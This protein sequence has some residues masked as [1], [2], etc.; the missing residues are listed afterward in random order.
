MYRG[1]GAS[2]VRFAPVVPWAKT[3]PD[4][5]NQGN[6]NNRSIGNVYR[7]FGNQTL[8]AVKRIIVSGA[9]KS[10]LT[11]VWL[12]TNDSIPI[13]KVDIV[14]VPSEKQTCDANIRYI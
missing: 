10:G 13:R 12:T 14:H 2:T 9:D 7:T 1:G 6:G 4:Y 11:A 5:N 3:G 8:S